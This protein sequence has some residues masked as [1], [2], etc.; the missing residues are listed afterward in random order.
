MRAAVERYNALLKAT[1]IACALPYALDTQNKKLWLDEHKRV[2][3]IFN[4]GS[5]E[6]GGRF[7]GGWWMSLKEEDRKHITINGEPTIEIDYVALHPSFSMR[8]R[9]WTTGNT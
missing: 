5:F 4:E 1:E 3:R 7:Y 2:H 9:A 8:D 6:K